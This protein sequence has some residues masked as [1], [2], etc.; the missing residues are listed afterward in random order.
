MGWKDWG[1]TPINS[2]FAPATGP[3]TSTLLAELDSTML[4]TVNYSASQ[5]ANFSVTWILGADTNVTWQCESCA[6]TALNAGVDVFYPKTATGQSAQ[7]ITT[8]RLGK[9][10]RLRARLYSTGANAAAYISAEPLT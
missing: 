1:N 8:H 6:S 7:F 3:S 5:Q 4:G 10:A 2:T 9:D